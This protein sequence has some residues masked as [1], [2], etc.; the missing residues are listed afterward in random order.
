MT[1]I[2]LSSESKSEEARR[3]TFGY[4]S[5]SLEC[6]NSDDDLDGAISD[7]EDDLFSSPVRSQQAKSDTGS[8]QLESGS[9][10]DTIPTDDEKPVDES[11][12]AVQ[13]LDADEEHEP[14]TLSRSTSSPVCKCVTLHQI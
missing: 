1:I 14:G 2:T 8:W 9:G 11:I 3:S 7:S 5:R 10:V 13:S 6:R 4:T 12:P